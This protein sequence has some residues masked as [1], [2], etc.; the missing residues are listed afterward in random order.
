MK[1]AGR[2]K[3]LV[4]QNRVAKH[5]TAI[6]KGRLHDPEISASTYKT[7]LVNETKSKDLMAEPPRAPRHLQMHERP[8]TGWE[9]TLCCHM[10]SM[11]FDA[12]N[13]TEEDT[14]C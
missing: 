3:I 2:L 13:N 1:K 14:K 9:P 4:K 5:L 12:E 11:P 7:V 10:D 6:V 8:K